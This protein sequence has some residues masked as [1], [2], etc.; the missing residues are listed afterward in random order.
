M[1]MIHIGP[2]FKILPF[3][4]EVLNIRQHE[5]VL[6]EALSDTSQQKEFIVLGLS[7]GAILLFH[8]SQLK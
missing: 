3:D 7:K 1:E 2:E 6:Q 8:L 4:Q 5:G